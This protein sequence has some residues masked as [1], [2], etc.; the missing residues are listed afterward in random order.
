MQ[1]NRHSGVNKVVRIL[2]CKCRRAT[3][4]ARRLLLLT[5]GDVERTPGAQMRG[6]QWN[7]GGYSQA[8]LDAL[9]RKLHEDT[10]LFCLF[11]MTRLA[12]AECAALKI[13]GCQH[14]VQARTPHVGDVSILVRGSGCGGGRS[15][16][17][18]HEESDSGTEVLSQCESHDRIGALPQNSKHFQR[19]A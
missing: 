6:A 10:V 3:P 14:V 16:K 11:Q 9:E 17:E 13:G 19:V 1:H 18:G 7:S 4:D 12:S 2:P 15:R 8:K 5:C